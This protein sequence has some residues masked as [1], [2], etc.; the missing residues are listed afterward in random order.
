MGCIRADGNRTVCPSLADWAM[1][2][3]NSKTPVPKAA[4]VRVVSED[5][6]LWSGYRRSRHARA[7]GPSGSWP[8]KRVSQRQT[9]K[10]IM[11][12]ARWTIPGRKDRPAALPS[13][14]TPGTGSCGEGKLDSPPPSSPHRQP[15][16]TALDDQVIGTIHR[17]PAKESQNPETLFHVLGL[18]PRFARQENDRDHSSTSGARRTTTRQR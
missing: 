11:P 15:Q 5:A 2:P 16:T 10:S 18:R 9:Q 17:E 6:D 1:P 8:P 7:S 14:P 4:P 13:E 12:P 3:T